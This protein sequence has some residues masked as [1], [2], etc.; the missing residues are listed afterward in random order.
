MG[1]SEGDSDT[2]GTEGEPA[3]ACVEGGV[4]LQPLAVIDEEAGIVRAFTP[5]GEH[6][7][8]AALPAGVNDYPLLRT[9]TDAGR[10][11]IATSYVSIKDGVTESGGVLRLYDYTNGALL[12]EHVLPY[13]V[14]RLFIDDQ[15]RITAEVDQGDGTPAG[16]F[17]I[18]G[19]VNE[20]SAFAPLGPIGPTGSIPGR[21]VANGEAGGFY[22]VQS[23][24]LTPVVDDGILWRV[25]GEAI[26]FITLDGTPNYVV[27]TPEGTSS[28]ALNPFLEF[29]YMN[30]YWD[31]AGDYRLF[32]LR[33]ANLGSEVIVRLDLKSGTV[34]EIPTVP[35]GLSP[36]ECFTRFSLDVEGRVYVALRDQGVAQLHVW[37]PD[38]AAWTT[39]GQPLTLIDSAFVDPRFGRVQVFR[40]IVYDGGEPPCKAS[41]W[42]DPPADA[43]AG[44]SYQLVRVDPPLGELVGADPKVDVTERCAAWIEDG[45]VRVRD[46]EDSDELTVPAVG[47]FL[48]LE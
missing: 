23:A 20:L 29:E 15:A 40:G 36:F 28:Y 32:S 10:L 24:E 11:A 37:D 39:I 41:E 38:S 43:L 16:L 22:D 18:D 1:G 46:L 2:G 26:E 44:W 48:W 3:S 45:G 33:D 42:V 14:T 4:L 17:V 47:S 9:A 13:S 35:P 7:L 30:Q 5:D 34:D 27:A 21:I 12:W 19:E 25:A 8:S 6:T 31:S